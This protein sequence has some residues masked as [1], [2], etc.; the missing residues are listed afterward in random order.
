[1]DCRA[2]ATV[3]LRHVPD[4]NEAMNMNRMRRG[5]PCGSP[6]TVRLAGELR[7][8]DTDAA[9]LAATETSE[10]RLDGGSVHAICRKER[11]IIRAHRSQG[12]RTRQREGEEAVSI[13]LRTMCRPRRCSGVSQVGS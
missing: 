5:P 8:E 13:V 9:I 10:V 12:R 4:R 2:P 1:M 11:E 6:W 7:I 3:A